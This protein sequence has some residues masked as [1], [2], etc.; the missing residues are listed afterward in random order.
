MLV[1]LIG[2]YLCPRLIPVEELDGLIIRATE[3]IWQVW[4]HRKVP[5]EVCVLID[6]FKLLTCVVVVDANLCIISSHY[7]P[8]LSRHELSASNWGISDL[9]GPDLCLLIV[10]V[11]DHGASIEPDENPGQRGMQ[12]DTLDALRPAQKLLLDLQLHFS[13]LLL[14]K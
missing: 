7:D 8:L 12:L 13:Y 2:I 10:V 6:D 1:I 14:L 3:Y 11:N 5:D 4:M 9:E